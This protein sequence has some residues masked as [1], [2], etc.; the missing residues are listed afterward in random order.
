MIIFPGAGFCIRRFLFLVI[1]NVGWVVVVFMLPIFDELS[2]T[3]FVTRG[4]ES[5]LIEMTDVICMS[6]M[7]VSL[8]NVTFGVLFDERTIVYLVG[9]ND[10]D[11]ILE[12]F[13]A[14]DCRR[15]LMITW[16]CDVGVA[17]REFGLLTE[18]R[19][20]CRD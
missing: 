1:V 20:N 5:L 18:G 4:G 19:E 2:T 15:L 8:D 11:C 12:V 7:F 14:F 13:V 6:K 10:D 17:G 3:C 16:F 9:L